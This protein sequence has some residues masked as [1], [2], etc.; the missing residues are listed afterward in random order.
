VANYYTRTVLTETVLLTEDLASILVARGA[1]LYEEDGKGENVLD[2]IVNERPPLK[3]YSVVFEDGWTDPCDDVDEFLIDYAGWDDEDAENASPEFRKLV[4]ED[5]HVI[6]REILKVND[7]K[8]E[9]DM[10]SGWGCSKMRLD[11]FGGSG[12]I[13]NRKG[14]LYLTSSHYEIDA[15]GTI[16][17]AGGFVSWDEYD[18]AA[19]EHDADCESAKA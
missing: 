1:Q 12:L 6:L 2:G 5:E 18:V 10:Q 4:I 19:A 7:D 15:D 16:K 11:G 13:V 17:H 9:I 3:R 14:Y 8:Q